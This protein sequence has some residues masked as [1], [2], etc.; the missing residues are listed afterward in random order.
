MSHSKIYGWPDCDV[1]RRT[2]AKG[3]LYKYTVMQIII[4]ELEEKEEAVYCLS[5][6]GYHVWRKQDV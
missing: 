2:A 5:H 1:A 3:L 6:N 4:P